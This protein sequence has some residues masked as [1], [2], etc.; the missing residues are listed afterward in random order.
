MISS[1]LDAALDAAEREVN[2]AKD[3]VERAAAQAAVDNSKREASDR[4]WIALAIISTYG[5]SILT[6]VVYIAFSVPNCS[7]DAACQLLLDAWFR[8]SEMLLQIIVTAIL[9]IVTLMLG[10]YFG[11]QSDKQ[12]PTG[13][14]Q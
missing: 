8:Q 11:K 7:E 2:V 6:V 3:D 4:T 5:L 1:S 12:S 10:F 13:N 9:P 14:N